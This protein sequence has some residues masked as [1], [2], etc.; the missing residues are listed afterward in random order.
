MSELQPVAPMSTPSSSGLTAPEFR[1]L[2]ESESRRLLARGHVG[3]IA[4]AHRNRV[5]IEP[6]HYVLDGDWIYGRTSVG[7]KLSMLSHN[8][9][10]A[11]E[12]DEVHD[13]FNWE[14]VVVKGA[15][16]I[17]D[18][19]LSDIDSYDRALYLMRGF[20]PDSLTSRDPAPHRM[21]LFRIHLSEIS[22]RAART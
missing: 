1:V 6:I 3:R 7:A 9:W 4:Y 21:V 18:P 20:V 14:S 2:T 22:G 17:L 16:H 5:E 13:T 15:F 12:T 10:C 11:F 19:E 8:P